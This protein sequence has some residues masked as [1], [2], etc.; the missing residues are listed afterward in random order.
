VSVALLR[1]ELAFVCSKM[2]FAVG[3]NGCWLCVWW[4]YVQQ[5]LIACQVEWVCHYHGFCDNLVICNVFLLW[6]LCAG[7]F[8][9]CYNPA[10]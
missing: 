6:F 1:H 3:V 4:Q 7:H 8:H 2:A 5:P 9:R 10:W